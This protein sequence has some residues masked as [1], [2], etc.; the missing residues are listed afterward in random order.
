M[1]ILPL[2]ADSMGVRSMAC[3]VK[4]SDITILIDPSAALGGNRFGLKPSPQEKAKLKSVKSKIQKIAEKADVIVISHYHW[5]HFDPKAKFF[6]DKQIFLK[7][8]RRNINKSQSERAYGFLSRKNPVPRWVAKHHEI[9][10][11]R[12]FEFGKTKL[13]FSPAFFHGEKKNKLG[14]VIIT[15]V[16]YGKQTFVHTSDVAG[17]SMRKTSNYLLKMRPDLLYIDGPPTLFLGWKYSYK[18]LNKA[19]KNLLGLIKT[20]KRKVILDHHLVRDR[21][22]IKHLPAVYKNKYGRK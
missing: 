8:Y 2:A 21:D 11:G 6:K 7:D 15:T 3:L 17:P 10:D 9:A 1:K 4:T 18:N 12:S 13:I 16:K 5:D 19:Q 20:S 22:Y 14:Y